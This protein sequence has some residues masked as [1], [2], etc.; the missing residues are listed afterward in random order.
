MDGRPADTDAPL[1]ITPCPLCAAQDAVVVWQVPYQRV[2]KQLREQWGVDVPT[3]LRGP[4]DE[5]GNAVLLRCSTCALEYFSPLLPGDGSFYELLSGFY[6]DD[7]WEFDEVRR[8]L[9][10]DDEVVDFGCGRGAFLTSARP[11]VRKVVGCD[12]NPAALDDA[13]PFEVLPAPFT[14]AAASRPGAFSVA[15]SFHVLEHV[16]DAREVLDA[17]RT[18]LRP[19]GRLYLSTPDRERTARAGFEVFDCPP[20]HVSRWSGAQFAELA[21]RHGWDL[22][23][24]DHE[25]FVHRTGKRR[26]VPRTPLYVAGLLKHALRGGVQRP[27][28]LRIGPADDRWPRGLAVLAEL[29]LPGGD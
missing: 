4:W 2:W 5:A 1:S 12:F 25:P 14:E 19:G 24:V 9:R 6:V 23:R 15:V 3:A 17:A 26:F 16:R 22:V 11:L 7:R 21:E 13:S 10:P 27:R 29:R 18:A 8:R 20:H 28:G